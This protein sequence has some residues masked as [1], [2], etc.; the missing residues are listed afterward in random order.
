MQSFPERNVFMDYLAGH[1]SEDQI[2]AHLQGLCEMMWMGLRLI[3]Y[4]LLC[5]KMITCTWIEK[6]KIKHTIISDSRSQL[7]KLRVALVMLWLGATIS[8]LGD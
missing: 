5:I 4:K 3:E 7:L 6:N 8:W 2:C 1:Y